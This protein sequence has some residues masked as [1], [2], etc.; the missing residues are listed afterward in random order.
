MGLSP[1]TKDR[2]LTIAG[3]GRA[4]QHEAVTYVR[5]GSSATGRYASSG[6]AMSA[7]PQKADFRFTLQHVCLLQIADIRSAA[8]SSLFDH[9]V[10]PRHS[11]NGTL[12][13]IWPGAR[14]SLRLDVGS[15]HNLAPF[16]DF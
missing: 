9:L 15:S 12:R 1:K 16:L 8:D 4:S 2:R 7:S 6:P 11:P 13:N 10:S 14:G 5:C 3:Q